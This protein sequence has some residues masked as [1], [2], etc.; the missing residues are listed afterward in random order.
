MTEEWRSVQH[1]RYCHTANTVIWPWS[2]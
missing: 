2:T 1:Y